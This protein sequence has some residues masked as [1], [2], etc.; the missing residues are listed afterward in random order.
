MIENNAGY[1]RQAATRGILVIE[2]R[3]KRD[4]QQ[5]LS[6]A[7]PRRDR[8]QHSSGDLGRAR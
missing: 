1:L 3:S 6:G 2:T 8:P 5:G 7:I 4:R